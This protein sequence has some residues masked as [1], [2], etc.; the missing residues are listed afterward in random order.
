MNRS[1]AIEL[2]RRL[3]KDIDGVPGLDDQERLGHSF[4]R[5]DERS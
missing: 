1:F 3:K 5:D 4:T 2:C